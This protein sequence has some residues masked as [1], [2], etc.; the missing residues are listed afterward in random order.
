MS[1]VLKHRMKWN[2][3]NINIYSLFAWLYNTFYIYIKNCLK[4]ILLSC[5]GRQGQIFVKSLSH[6]KVSH[7]V[8]LHLLYITNNHKTTDS[9]SVFTVII[10][11]QGEPGKVI[12][13]PVKMQKYCL[14]F[15]FNYKRGKC[16]QKIFQRPH[17]VRCDALLSVHFLHYSWLSM[18]LP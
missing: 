5:M 7:K 3:I 10:Y 2:E 14:V 11:N 8:Q 9:T 16:V 15:F 1:F 4:V 6:M 12:R 18:K 13:C 17:C